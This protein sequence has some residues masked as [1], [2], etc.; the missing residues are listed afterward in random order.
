[1]ALDTALRVQAVS[2][3]DLAHILKFGSRY[4]ISGTAAL[5]KLVSMRGEEE[6]MSE[7]DSKARSF[8]CSAGHRYRCPSV[9]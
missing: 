8:E 7:S 2:F 4:R 3:D 6:A 1:M 5:R 9:R